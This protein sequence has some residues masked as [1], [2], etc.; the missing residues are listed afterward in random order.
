MENKKAQSKVN[1]KFAN[2]FQPTQVTPIL[3]NETKLTSSADTDAEYDETLTRTIST[4]LKH[5]NRF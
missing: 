2:T 4:D 1:L 3:R 5:E